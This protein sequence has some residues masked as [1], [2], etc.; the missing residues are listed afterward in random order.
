M[1]EGALFMP[2]SNMLGGYREPV[3]GAGL[4]LGG[5][6]AEGVF[7]FHLHEAGCMS[8]S[9]EW[10][11]AQVRSP[12][13]RLYWNDRPGAWISCSG[14]RLELGPG[15]FL[16]VPSH[17]AFDTHGAARELRHFWIH[18][19]LHPDLTVKDNA[20]I[21]VRCGAGMEREVK[22]LAKK[23]KRGEPETM[24]QIHHL[25][26]ALLHRVFADSEAE[27]HP[28][29]LPARLYALLHEIESGLGGEIAVTGLAQRAG[30]SRGGFIRWF[31]EHMEVSPARYVL[32]RRIDHACRLLKFSAATVEEISARLGF[33][34][35][36][37]FSR[38]FQ[39]Q[40]GLGPAGF[41]KG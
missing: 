5:L 9:T 10:D 41:R 33:A 7:S 24:R 2:K 13:W 8:F 34:N 26:S 4:R 28:A 14:R 22:A 40:M 15:S 29:R 31:K 1:R 27:A 3:T 11:Y 23:V 16:L 32:G 17:V 30:M 21:R 38:V 18:F 35:R 19:S 25:C 39:R 36:G 12:F 6:D 37:H 20:P